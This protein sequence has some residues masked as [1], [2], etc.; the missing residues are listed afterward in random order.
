MD[1]KDKFVTLEGAGLLYNSVKDDIEDLN[2]SL[3]ALDDRKIGFATVDGEELVLK[4]SANSETE[5]ARLS[6]FG[7]GGGGGA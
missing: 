6:G 5:I 4:S 7:G 2:D 1:T 3:S